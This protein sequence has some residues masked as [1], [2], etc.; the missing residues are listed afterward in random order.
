MKYSLLVI[1]FVLASCGGG[2]EDNSLTGKKQK[3]TTLQAEVKKL[4]DEI[5][6]L[7]PKKEE[8]RVKNVTVSPLVAQSFK[9]YVDVQGTLEAE[10]NQYISPQMGGA[11]TALLVK[12]GDFVKKG[13]TIAKVENAVLKTSMQ[14]I[15][16]QLET[17]KTMYEK[18]KALWDQKI[19]TEVQ[20]IQAKTGVDALEK[21][22]ATLNEQIKMAVV[23]TPISGYVDEVRQR[24][25]EMAMPGMGIIRV[26][27]FD[28]LKV[29]ANV[30]D[31]YAGTIKKGDLVKITFPDLGKEV[32]ARLSFVNM[33]VNPVSRT[34]TAEAL[35][36]NIDK[37]LKP[38]MLAIVNINDQAKANAIVVPQ[39]IVQRTEQG[40]VVYIAVEEG[41]QKIA[42]GRLV[43]TGLSYNGQIEIVSGL[44]SGDL[45]ITQGYQEL[46]DGQVVSY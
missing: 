17:A 41:K 10:N 33:T 31:V 9:H 18:Q 2:G 38:N 4:Q 27:N 29:K 12:E 8:V 45:L 36:P 23:T 22:M 6:K 26:V 34:F 19:G 24:A 46:V 21:R 14:E 28:N 35:I 30:A 15:E 25:G 7:D 42:K 37:Q 43:K 32:N 39:N 3:L 1:S 40:D 11:I 20:Y 13:Q 5:A 44:Q 16:V